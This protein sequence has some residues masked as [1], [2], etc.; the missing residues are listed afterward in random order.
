MR[1]ACEYIFDSNKILVRLLGTPGDPN[2]NLPPTYVQIGNYAVDFFPT[3]TKV[4]FDIEQEQI[5][6]NEAKIY[7]AS[8]NPLPSSIQVTLPDLTVQTVLLEL[9]KKPNQPEKILAEQN[10]ET[11]TPVETAV[12]YPAHAEH[13]IDK[14]APPDFPALWLE[15]NF[16]NADPLKLGKGVTS[17]FISYSG[18]AA[19]RLL[20]A[21]TNQE[22][23]NDPPYKK[24]GNTYL[25]GSFT[26]SLPGSDFTT[27]YIPPGL[28]DPLPTGWNI[29][30]A[31]V[32]GMIR[33]LI[34]PDEER[35]IL[36]PTLRTVWSQRPG[37]QDYSLAPPVTF[38]TPPVN[39]LEVFQV[40]L[41]P[42]PTNVL[43]QVQLRSNTSLVTTP[44]VLLDAP[45]VLMLNV[46]TDNGP[47]KIVW[48]QPEGNGSHQILDIV[49]PQSSAYQTAHSYVPEGTTNVSD[50]LTVSNILYNK[51]AL[52]QGFLR[53]ESET[54]TLNQPISWSLKFQGGTTFLQVLNGV[55]SSDYATLVVSLSGYLSPELATNGNYKLRWDGSNPFQMATKLV[56]EVE[57]T[58]VL[59]F[60]FDIPIPDNV[61]TQALTFEAKSFSSTAGSSRIKY[62]I[63]KP[64]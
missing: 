61:L 49:A 18:G 54:D 44:W 7:L 24:H 6:Q 23:V 57:Q 37:Y 55:L 10:L 30:L 17:D 11:I 32:N 3:R 39:S 50:V 33:T 59:P 45:K 4:T 28:L 35:G 2:Q 38:I 8:V 36:L 63:F 46:G 47:V 19:G 26:N 22:A 31:D 60:A 12:H 58:V 21:T 25:E 62:F 20:S 9:V 53:F 42:A 41:V 51:W 16:S 48:N 14:M 5:T 13:R 52:Q 56:N 27:S 1:V 29:Q 64:E 15:L 34:N 43:A 40:L